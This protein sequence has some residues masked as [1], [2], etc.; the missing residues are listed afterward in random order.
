MLGKWSVVSACKYD[1]RKEKVSHAVFF[2]Y[3]RH[4]NKKESIVYVYVNKFYC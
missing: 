3:L 1:P 4:A 2:I